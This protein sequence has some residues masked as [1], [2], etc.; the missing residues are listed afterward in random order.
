MTQVKKSL[1]TYPQLGCS[2]SKRLEPT[3]HTSK[4]Q[5]LTR[6]PSVKQTTLQK[7]V[8]DTLDVNQDKYH[9]IVADHEHK[10]TVIDNMGLSI[11]HILSR[12]LDPTT[13]HAWEPIVLDRHTIVCEIINDS[14]LYG[15]ANGTVFSTSTTLLQLPLPPACI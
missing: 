15:V 12:L 10:R 8:E 2:M 9:D 4:P 13:T 11:F 14:I 1:C 7:L 5:Q 6:Q 3:I